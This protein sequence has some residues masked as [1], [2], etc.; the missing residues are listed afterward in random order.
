MTDA[1]RYDDLF[2]DDDAVVAQVE[3]S[4]GPKALRDAYKK[5]KADK[6]AAEAELKTIRDTQRESEVTS[7]LAEA[8][9]PE[10]LKEDAE[11][12]SD[13]DAWIEARRGL[14]AGAAT[15]NADAPSAEPTGTPAVS[16][17]QI[18]EMRGVQNI[19][20]GSYTPGSRDEMAAKVDA[21]SATTLE[22]FDAELAK[23]GAFG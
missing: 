14:F 12:A 1:N 18:E 16:P 20:P 21:I 2:K 11:R 22:E 3:Q 15:P 6:E 4:E 8:G 23:L 10:V 13:L 19:Q 5:L 9:I 17:E 7:K